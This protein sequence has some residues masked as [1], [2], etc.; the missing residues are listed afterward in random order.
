[1]DGPPAAV[2]RRRRE[3]RTLNCKRLPERAHCRLCNRSLTLEL[4]APVGLLPQL[5]RGGSGTAW[6]GSTGPALKNR[7]GRPAACQLEVN[8]LTR[9]G[10]GR[11]R[12]RGIDKGKT[13][14]PRERES[15]ETS[16]NSYRFLGLFWQE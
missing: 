8:G 13:T 15:A 5:F 6:A 7:V 9:G 12:T 14:P 16:T 10:T 3:I 11:F 1:M 2:P 4:L